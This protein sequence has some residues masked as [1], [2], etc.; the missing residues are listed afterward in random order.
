[1]YIELVHG[2]YKPTYIFFGGTIL[3]TI[4]IPWHLRPTLAV[5][6]KQFPLMGY[7]RLNKKKKDVDFQK[8]LVDHFP[9]QTMGFPHRCSGLPYGSRSFSE[10]HDDG[11]LYGC[12]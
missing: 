1:M 7:P 5:E 10:K 8:P 6:L 3:Y 2:V 4:L 9:K 11:Q 12:V